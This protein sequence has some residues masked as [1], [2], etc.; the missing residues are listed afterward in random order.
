VIKSPKRRETRQKSEPW[1]CF[2]FLTIVIIFI[3]LL[4]DCDK[5]RKASGTEAE[6][7][8]LARC[9]QT[10]MNHRK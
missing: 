8:E 3:A 9:L 7:N 10:K 4:S 6:E 2:K 1:R 5:T